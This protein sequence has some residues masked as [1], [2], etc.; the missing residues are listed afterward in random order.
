V[1]NAIEPG[2]YLMGSQFTA[3]D[4]IVGSNLRWGMMFDLIPKRA[5]FAAYVG[6]LE[7]RP[8]LQRATAA[9]QALAGA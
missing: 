9:D 5:E 8:A 7:Q 3:A 4:V 2:P 1:A 6:R